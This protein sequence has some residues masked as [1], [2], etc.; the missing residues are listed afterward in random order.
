MTVIIQSNVYS[1]LLSNV[2]DNQKWMTQYL[3]YLAALFSISALSQCAVPKAVQQLLLFTWRNANACPFYHSKMLVHRRLLR[4]TV[5]AIR[6]MPIASVH[7]ALLL[8]RVRARKSTHSLCTRAHWNAN[9]HCASSLPIPPHKFSM[10]ILYVCIHLNRELEA[11]IK[12][13][14]GKPK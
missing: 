11:L 4:P 5:Y 3:V 2:Y 14:K 9:Y 6:T 1:C 8:T 7:S 12:F 10:S 13:R